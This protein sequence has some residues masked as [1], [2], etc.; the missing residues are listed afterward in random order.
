MQPTIYDYIIVGA[1][2]A[3]C[4]LANRLTACG[5]FNVLLVEAGP[6]PASWFS[7]TPA[8]FARFMFGRK[9]NW[10]YFSK[11]VADIR[12]GEPIFTPRGKMV[13]G[14]GA[15]NAMIYIRGHASDYDAWAEAGNKGWGFEDMLPY[16]KKAECNQRGSDHWHSNQGPLKVSDVDIAFAPSFSFMQ[17]CQQQGLPFNPDFNGPELAG[18]GPY[19]F[20]WHNGRRFGARQAYLDPVRSRPNLSVMSDTL[21]SRVL[22]ENNRATG[23]ICKNGQVFSTRREV[24]LSGGTFNS[25]QLLMLSGIGPAKQ[26]LKHGIE[27]IHDLPGVGEN[28]QEHA[29]ASVMVSCKSFAG[30][31]LN[32]FSLA[33]RL[34]ALWQYWRKRK[35][36][37][38]SAISETGAFCFS[39][40]Q[41]KVPDIQLHFM[42]ALYDNSGRN[43]KL[44][45][46]QGFSCHFCLLRPKSRGTVRLSGKQITQPPLIDYNFL[47]HKDDI[48][49]LLSGFRLA[50]SI[51]Q[52]PAF[53]A[54]RVKEIH[55]G[56]GLQSDEDLLNALKSRLGLIYHPVGTCKMGADNMAVVDD[57]LRVHGLHNLRVIDASIIPT[58]ISGNT[59]APTIALA[60]KAADLILSSITA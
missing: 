43:L 31:S 32:P 57:Q 20:T 14:S 34:P 28:L 39:N 27:L 46:Q 29:D 40:E 33:M 10:H 9:Y 1:G 38:S 58:L 23:I 15:V 52:Q 2:S 60:E 30:I 53:S 16:F 41:L 35:G 21:V 37:L 13:G 47:D 59:N 8:G 56:N 26:L 19:Q 18:Y 5:R 44:A 11:P 42:P 50:R 22:L 12:H 49:A 25:P 6:E 45:M 24:I 48:K 3:G 36:L 55:P 7:T 17:A 51:M 54:F 4:V